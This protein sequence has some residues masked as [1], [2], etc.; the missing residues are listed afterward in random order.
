[1]DQLE[2]LDR[3]FRLVGLQMADQMPDRCPGER[4][5]L[6]ARFLDAV[7][8][9]D[10]D[11]GFERLADDLDRHGLADRNQRDARRLASGTRGRRMDALVNVEE[12]VANGFSHWDSKLW[13]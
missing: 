5:D 2:E 7:F 1:M 8:A 10:A 12:A 9:Q 11:A 4:G 13:S 3:L 6:F